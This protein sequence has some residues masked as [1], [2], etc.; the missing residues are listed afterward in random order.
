MGTIE[1]FQTS[2]EDEI[3]KGILRADNDG[4]FN[5]ILRKWFTDEYSIDLSSWRTMSSKDKDV[6]LNVCATNDG[7]SLSVAIQTFFKGAPWFKAL[8]E[9]AQASS[10]LRLTSRRC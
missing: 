3:E 4:P 7:K 2:G 5:K 6:V 9:S 8:P 1:F 10:S